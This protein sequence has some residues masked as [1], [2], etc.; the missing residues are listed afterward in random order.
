MSRPPL[1]LPR[2]F[3]ALLT[4]TLLGAASLHAAGT[5]SPQIQQRIDALLKRRLTPVALPIDLPNPFQVI[6]G[7]PSAPA[8]DDAIS[9]FPTAE[10]VAA[11]ISASG[12]TK[13]SG[14]AGPSN[15]DVLSAI[16]SRLKFGGIIVLK[17]QTKVVING[18]PRRE[19]DMMPADWNNAVVYLKVVK[20]L[21]DQVVLRYVDV[22]ATLKF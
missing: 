5:P 8:P 22:D 19:G 17:D 2:A 1:P 21:P 10:E 6:T 16:V 20:L 7:G 15:V 14:S 13:S 11:G 4:A 9:K 18:V 12:E 3:A